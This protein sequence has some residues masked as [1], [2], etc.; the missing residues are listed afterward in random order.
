MN[1]FL[2]SEISFAA[3]LRSQGY[4]IVQVQRNGRKVSWKFEISPEDL[5]RV[6]AEWPQSDDAKFWTA[7][8]TLKGQLRQ[9]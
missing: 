1:N 3:H 6:E 9:D 8:Q 4:K 5:S 2:T 7:Y